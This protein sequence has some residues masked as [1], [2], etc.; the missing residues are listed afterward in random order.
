MEGG[1]WYAVEDSFYFLFYYCMLDFRYGG[2]I[3]RGGNSFWFVLGVVVLFRFLG[4]DMDLGKIAL[5]YSLRKEYVFILWVVRVIDIE[6]VLKS[7]GFVRVMVVEVLVER[8]K[9]L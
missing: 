5:V 2:G 3:G 7:I 6:F 1:K 9:K 4:K 8:F